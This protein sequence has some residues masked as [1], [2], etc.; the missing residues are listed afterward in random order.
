MRTYNLI[1]HGLMA[2][3]ISAMPLLFSSTVFA[4]GYVMQPQSRSYACQLSIN[5]QCGPI[6][7][8]PQ[9]LEGPNN[10][11]QAGPADGHIASAG[12]ERFKELD[13][14]SPTRWI[15]THLS[16]GAN[17]FTWHN[18]ALH[19]TKG[20]R[21]FI[22]KQGWNQSAALTRDAF[23]LQPF[24]TVNGNGKPATGEVTHKCSIPLDRSGY[25]VILAIWDIADTTNSFYN[26]IDVDIDSNGTTPSTSQ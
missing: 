7:W 4:H 9:S 21:Y 26:T 22:T 15:K 16:T 8:E 3:T 25:H 23:D 12:K 17:Q 10:F 6:M 20:W 11:P 5:T 14:Q 1:K 19:A 24:C 2:L 18:T 13:E